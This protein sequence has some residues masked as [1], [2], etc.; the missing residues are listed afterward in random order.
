MLNVG[1]VDITNTDMRNWEAVEIGHHSSMTFTGTMT[2]SKGSIGTG[3]SDVNTRQPLDLTLDGT[4]N[5]GGN[6]TLDSL[7]ITGN[8]DG[9]GTIVINAN[10]LPPSDFARVGG[11]SSTRL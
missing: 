4:L 5:A 10:M 9:S 11:R 1:N 2:F 6:G 8:V 7:K 3:L